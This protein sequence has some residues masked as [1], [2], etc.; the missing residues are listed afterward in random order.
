MSNIYY[1]FSVNDH[2]FTDISLELK[3]LTEKFR[4]YGLAYAK[5]AYLENRIFNH[6]A[7]ISDLMKNKSAI[8]YEFLRKLEIEYDLTLSDLI[9]ADRHLMRFSPRHRLEI[10][11]T[12]LKIFLNEIKVYK[13][14]VVFTAS[15]ADFISLFASAYCKKNN[16]VFRYFITSGFGEFFCFT[17]SHTMEPIGFKN[18]Y[19]AVLQEAKDPSYKDKIHKQRIEFFEKKIQPGYVTKA[20]FQFKIFEWK[21]IHSM[22]S[23]FVSYFKDPNG[24]HHKSKPWMLPFQRL[25]RVIR[26]LQYTKCIKAKELSLDQVKKLKFILYPLQFYP[27]AS[28]IVQGRR[29]NDQFRMIEMIS[30]ALPVDVTL[31]VKEHKVCIGRRPIDFYTSIANVHNVQFVNE[32]VNNFELI[33]HSKGI[34]TIS[35]TM[36]LEALL[37]NKPVLVFGE[38]YYQSWP[39]TFKATDFRN[40]KTQIENML[41]YQCDNDASDIIFEAIMRSSYNIGFFLPSKYSDEQ[42]KE[43]AAIIYTHI[44]NSLNAS[45]DKLL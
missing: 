33:K 15:V 38:R 25:T 29:F 8:D 18:T 32:N 24:L 35:S 28:T 17:D 12:L 19:E 6:I 39:N 27:E 20:G 16:I 31:I 10:S 11:Q 1:L 23:Y 2:I 43:L 3:K 41:S 45:G 34:A 9:H 5:T 22:L 26:K 21:D 7:Y 4:F 30:K 36:G 42:L 40:L 37:L 44:N 14:D 13:I